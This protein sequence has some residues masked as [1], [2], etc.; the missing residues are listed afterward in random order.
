MN[1]TLVIFTV[2]IGIIVVWV[3][4]RYRPN[5][6]DKQILIV[7]GYRKKGTNLGTWDGCVVS[8]YNI[9]NIPKYT[10]FFGAAFVDGRDYVLPTYP[11]P[12]QKTV[13]D[14]MKNEMET[15]EYTELMT[16]EDIANTT[17]IKDLKI[18]VVTA[19]YFNPDLNVLY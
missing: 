1:Y 2:I 15:K 7:S 8:I 13:Y 5:K 16:P 12:T 9:N 10:K 17:G 6:S 19:D 4:I 3:N 14:M 18:I 11:P